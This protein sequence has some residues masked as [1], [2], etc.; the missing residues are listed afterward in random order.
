MDIID[1]YPV[2][3]HYIGLFSQF[4]L[5]P[6]L[7]MFGSINMFNAYFLMYLAKDFA[8]ESMLADNAMIAHH[9]I[10]A[11]GTIYFSTTKP[12][13][14]M[15]TIAE[16]G[17]GSYNAYTLAKAYYQDV[18]LVYMF[19]AIVMSLSNVYCIVS[20]VRHNARWYYKVPALAL[21]VGRQAFVYK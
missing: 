21:I 11:W 16:V 8:Y 2:Y 18:Y 6:I 19:Y 5:F 1:G 15:I 13:C 3:V 7:A 17:S 20:I 14:W 12:M 9:V 10:S 4:W